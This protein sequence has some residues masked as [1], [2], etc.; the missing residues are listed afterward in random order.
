MS[1]DQAMRWVAHRLSN[2]NVYIDFD[3]NFLT[4]YINWIH[5]DAKI[6]PQKLH[7]CMVM[8]RIKGGG[9]LL[10]KKMLHAVN[11][12][13]EKFEIIFLTKDKNLVTLF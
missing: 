4:N 3:V 10:H 13:A 1:R 6:T 2:P 9:G 5:S 8:Y 7:D 11:H 12:V